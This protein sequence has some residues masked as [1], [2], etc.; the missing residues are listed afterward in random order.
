MLRY[1]RPVLFED[2]AAELV[3]LDL[4]DDAHASAFQPEF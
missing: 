2:L 3:D 4:A 1:L